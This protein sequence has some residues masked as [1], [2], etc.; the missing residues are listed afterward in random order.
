RP[1]DFL[2]IF[3]G[4]EDYLKAAPFVRPG[5]IGVIGF[6]M[7]GRLAML[8]GAREKKVRAV[9]AF[10]PGVTKPEQVADLHVPVQ[11]HHGTGDRSVAYTH[12]LELEKVLKNQST[13]VEVFLYDKLDHGFLAYTRP[14]Y[15]PDGA[16]LAWS[17]TVAFLGKHLKE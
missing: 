14:F 5:K 6:C 17:R 12:T 11:I 3:E 8:F 2:Q 4:A 15:D 13:P 1:V 10:H 16:K 7:G 9:V